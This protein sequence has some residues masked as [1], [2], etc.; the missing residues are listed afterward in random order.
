M[1]TE[2]LP[3]DPDALREKYR[4][5]RDMLGLAIAQAAVKAGI[6]W[7]NCELDGPTLVMLCD[8]LA[9][10]ARGRAPEPHD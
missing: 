6:I 8:D 3:F 10:M 9:T 5:E 2:T 7:Q 4:A 1:T